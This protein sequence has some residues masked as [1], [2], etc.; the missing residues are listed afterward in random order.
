MV[1]IQFSSG[2]VL[3]EAKINE[4]HEKIKKILKEELPE[5]CQTGEV[6]DYILSELKN[7]RKTW[8]VEL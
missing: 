5:D 7:K 2:L 8:K 6:L 1:G 3:T 4:V